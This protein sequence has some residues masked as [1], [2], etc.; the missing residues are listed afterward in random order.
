MAT[1]SVIQRNG[2]LKNIASRCV[3]LALLLSLFLSTGCE[4]DD[5]GNAAEE[6]YSQ[7]NLVSNVS[8]G[9]AGR[10][11]SNFINAWGVALDDD[12]NFWITTTGSNLVYVLDDEGEEVQ[13]PVAVEG[14]P[15][16]I[17]YNSTSDFEMPGTGSPAKFI[18]ASGSGIL[19][20]WSTGGSAVKVADNSS[21]DAAYTGIAIAEDG[22]SNF[23]YVANFA[24][25]MIEVYDT[26]FNQVMNK[27]FEDPT[28]PDGYSPFNIRHIDDQLY[29]VYAKH[30]ASDPNEEEIGVGL[31][32]VSVFD[33]D[34]T[35]VKRFASQGKLNAPW[36]IVEAPSAFGQT[37][38]AILVG[39]FGDGYI[40]V[41]DEDGNYLHQLTD[42]ND[43][44]I[45]IEG[46]WA[47]MF[48][49][50]RP[51]KL[52]FTAGPNDENNGLFGY[53]EEQ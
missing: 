26:D 40:N 51:E 16:G 24:E 29:V 39:N 6:R 13:A 7:T 42:E 35:F 4:D 2:R 46:L 27:S 14:A 11:D 23:I 17:V 48:E 33:T 18:F 49:D 22:D 34:G 44:L 43:E 12:D 1:I 32:Y 9:N 20:A 28:L 30:T 3:Y 19:S 5:A 47:L 45:S 37:D 52:Y 10:V 15:I 50:G 41:F 38:D 31:G 8:G 53:L 36:G 25:G 21:E